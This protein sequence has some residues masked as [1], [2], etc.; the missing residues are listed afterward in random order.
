[1]LSLND[2]DSVSPMVINLTYDKFLVL[3]CW[4]CMWVSL[5]FLVSFKK[6]FF[7]HLTFAWW[8]FVLSI[9]ENNFLIFVSYL[10]RKYFNTF[11]IHRK[12]KSYFINQKNL[13]HGLLLDVHLCRFSLFID[14]YYLDYSHCKSL[15]KKK[16]ESSKVRSVSSLF[17]TL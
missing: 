6:L 12:I 4:I 15:W 7:K 14:Y 5:T 11:I 17:S 1:M 8:L 9:N 3:N 10:N 2:I 13:Y 16:A